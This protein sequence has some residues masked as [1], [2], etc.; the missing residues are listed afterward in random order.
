[1]SGGALIRWQWR[2]DAGMTAPLIVNKRSKLS[3]QARRCQPKA[4]APAPLLGIF[5]SITA[6]E[7][8]GLNESV[9]IRAR[10]VA[11]GGWQWL[12]RQD[13]TVGRQLNGIPGN[14][15]TSA[16]PGKHDICGEPWQ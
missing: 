14:H 3:R 7:L 13:H 12:L 16:W 2:P 15:L 9:T 11:A 8:K 4:D 10:E 1:M 5:P 6:T